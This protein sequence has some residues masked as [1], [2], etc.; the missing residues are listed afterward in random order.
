[1]NLSQTEL[2]VGIWVPLTILVGSVLIRSLSMA[3]V[4]KKTH[5]TK[6]LELAVNTAN[7]E[8]AAFRSTVG[9]SGRKS[10]PMSSYV[11]FH[12]A[13]FKRMERVGRNYSAAKAVEETL[14]EVI[15]IFP[16]YVRSGLSDYGEIWEVETN[17]RLDRELPVPRRSEGSAAQ[18]GSLSPTAS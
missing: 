11:A 4:A 6:M 3:Y 5:D 16:V 2:I 13:F 1:M 17:T 12:L 7:S 8:F 14:K 15:E 9:D 10:R 18:T